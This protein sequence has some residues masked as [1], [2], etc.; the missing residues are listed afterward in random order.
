MPPALPSRL[1]A[2]L[3]V[4]LL[5]LVP[6]PALR[7]ADKPTP[8]EREAVR[9][10]V[11]GASRS[12]F[13]Y[14]HLRELC[15]GIGHRMAGSPAM[16]R[17]V[18]WSEQVMREAG[19][20]HVHREP[21]AVPHWIRG[22]ESARIVSPIDRPL[23]MLG[24]GLSVATPPGGV[25]APVVVVA[26]FE[27]L[28][29][30]GKPGVEGKIVLFDYPWTGYPAAAEIRSR[31]PSKAAALGAVAALVRSATPRNHDT[32]HTGWLS[33]P[34]GI[35]RIPSA[36]LS[37]TAASQVRRLLETGGEVRIHLEMDHRTLENTESHN[38]IGEVIGRE[39]PD[40]IVLLAAHL[41]SWDVGQGAQD[42]GVG[43]LIMLEV[44]RLIGE[45]PVP[46]R[47]TVRVV[48]FTDEEL[49]LG[50]A[51]SYLELHQD[52]LSRHVAGFES[53]M[54]NEV[55]DG[56]LIDI[57][58]VAGPIDST[59]GVAGPTDSTRTAEAARGLTRTVMA[60]LRAFD[61]ALSPLGAGSFLPGEG[62]ID[63]ADAV[64]RGMLG[65]GVN[66]PTERYFDIHHS[67][68]DTFD[69]VDP[70][71]LSRNVARVATMVYLVAD[72]PERLLP[73]PG[74]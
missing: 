58:G 48:L 24:L 73:W 12:R 15:E 55:A 61:W 9:R 35:P 23:S 10:L 62:G 3:L 30:L 67:V 29:R 1:A 37:P 71:D 4:A 17:A 20:V 46:P 66:H 52:E 50:G 28:A 63:I 53:D 33:R 59:R 36:A 44:A 68:L 70:G 27:E 47:R 54:G 49:H 5:L 60:R 7:G 6:A 64:K 16:R 41:D 57:R 31:G 38:V 39:R 8:G 56:F 40:E 32:P 43:C 69:R 18:D 26:S 19:L 25:T 14:E 51:D 72:A 74:R 65:L 42:D 11:D 22:A 21:A 45:L 13:G 34:K 2:P